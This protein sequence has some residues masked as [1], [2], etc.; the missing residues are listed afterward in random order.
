VSLLGAFVQKEPSDAKCYGNDG[1]DGPASVKMGGGNC[2]NCGKFGIGF[3]IR[4]LKISVC[5]KE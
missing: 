3:F 1:S 5:C 2:E 4:F